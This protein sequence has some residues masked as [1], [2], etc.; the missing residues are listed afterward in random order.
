MGDDVD[1][2]DAKEAADKL[3]WAL[4]TATEVGGFY[5]MAKEDP[6]MSTIIRELYG[7][8]P[9]RTTSVFEALVTAVTSQQIASH[10]ARLIRGLLIQTYGAQFFLDGRVYY[11]FPTPE[12]I[13]AAGIGGLR[14]MK[15]ST[16]KCEYLLD[17]ASKVTSGTIRLES[18]HN[19][20]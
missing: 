13:Q 1:E 12:A 18:L 14:N 16:R 5:S 7:L 15:L 20:P 19:L 3:A 6:V 11:S 9:T 2:N 17:T 4:G 8:H 10:V